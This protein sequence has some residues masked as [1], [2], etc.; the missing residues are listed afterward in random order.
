M[1]GGVAA[2]RLGGGGGRRPWQPPFYPR[3]IRFGRRAV[4][5]RAPAR[6]RPS[7]PR[8][9][10]SA[11]P[12]ATAM[13]VR[14][15]G[16]R[17]ARRASRRSAA[18]PAGR[19][20]AA[21]AAGGGRWGPALAAMCDCRRKARQKSGVANVDGSRRAHS[22]GARAQP[23]PA[24][25]PAPRPPPGTPRRRPA[26]PEPAPDGR[27]AAAAA[28]PRVPAGRRAAARPCVAWRQ[29][30]RCGEAGGRW[31]GGA[32]RAPPRS[33]PSFRRRLRTR[34]PRP[35]PRAT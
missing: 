26:A 18:P 1:G 20:P 6:M 16:A 13:A 30:R 24:S 27:A 34:A 32:D 22:R 35:R 9:S 5:P 21:A 29:R 7:P 8:S 11:P 17:G 19:G 25:Q 23:Q 12:S 15:R 2:P 4:A 31:E 3:P 33:Q 28:A 10:V 14:R